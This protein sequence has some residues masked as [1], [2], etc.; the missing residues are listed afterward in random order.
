MNLAKQ[1]TAKTFILGP[2]LDS[3]GA[4]KTDEVVASIKVTKNG[5]VG[6]VDAHDTLT[7][8]HTGHYVFVS[9]G[10]DFGTLGEVEFSLNS[11]T[12]AMA[13]KSFQVVAANVYNAL[14]AGGD[15]LD[16]AVAEMTAGIIANAT[17]AN[18]TTCKA[19][20][21]STMQAGSGASTAVLNNSA[22]DKNN[23]YDGDILH[24]TAGTAAGESQIIISYVGSSRTA[25]VAEAW[26]TIPVLGDTYVI[27]ALGDVEVGSF[28][29]AAKAAINAEVDT[30]LNTAIP[31]G[32]TA[33]SINERI[34]A[35][36]GFGTPPS[37]ADI[38]TTM[39]AAG[40]TLAL[41]KTILDKVDNMIE[42]VP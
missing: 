38:K 33:D 40:S 4:A 25:T 30:A 6:A 18:D 39:E 19:V 27:Q 12:N 32:P 21:T 22:S 28:S 31:G 41:S 35:I 11:G 3:L 36:D 1:S 13:P 14:V 20:H 29:T 10:D 24:I 2:I 9:D 15:Y 7:H 17:F 26:G 42:V 5:T 8:N 34:V 23:Y 16:V 37:A